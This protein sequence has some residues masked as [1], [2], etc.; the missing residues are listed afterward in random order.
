[1]QKRSTETL[2]ADLN[3]EPDEW[4]SAEEMAR[5]CNLKT[6]WVVTRIQEEVLHGEHRNGQYF[7]SCATVWRVQQIEQI[8]RQFDADPHLA[9][10]VTDLMDEVRRLRTQLRLKRRD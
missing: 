6:E 9:G 2:L 7:L 5:A 8:E 10:L 4:I 3:W 1:M